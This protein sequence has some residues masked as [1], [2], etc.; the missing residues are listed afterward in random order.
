MT[1]HTCS[2]VSFLSASKLP[3]PLTPPD[4][5]R[6]ATS[7]ECL[8]SIQCTKEI[9]HQLQNIDVPTSNSPDKISGRMLK[10][11]AHSI[12]CSITKLFNLSIQLG[13]FPQTWK[14]SNV[15][16]IPKSVDNTS[17][18]NLRPISLLLVL[19]KH[20]EQH[21]YCLTTLYPALNGD[22]SREGQQSLHCWKQ[23]TIGSS[24]WM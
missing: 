7:D 22:S 9:V 16:P 17:P 8:G 5:H 12:A 18:T 4:S 15:V 10:A 21:M 13:C 1:R 20:L 2:I 11:T 3:S 24:L 19:S 23:L 6:L 14:L